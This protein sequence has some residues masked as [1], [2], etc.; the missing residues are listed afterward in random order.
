VRGTLVSETKQEESV[1]LLSRKALC[2]ERVVNNCTVMYCTVQ[3]VFLSAGFTE[4]N[5]PLNET[6]PRSFPGE[7]IFNSLPQ[8]AKPYIFH[9][10]T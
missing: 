6:T 1:S 10:Y 9:D 4:T 8:T 5:F 2:A 3:S 7:V